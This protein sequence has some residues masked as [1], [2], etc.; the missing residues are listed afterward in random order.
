VGAI[1]EREPEQSPVARACRFGRSGYKKPF[2]YQAPEGIKIDIKTQEAYEVLRD[3]A[4]YFRVTIGQYAG[5]TLRYAMSGAPY[6]PPPIKFTTTTPTTKP[7]SFQLPESLYAAIEYKVGEDKARLYIATTLLGL[8]RIDLENAR[9][10][11]DE[12]DRF[13]PKATTQGHAARLFSQR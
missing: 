12:P 5:R 3:C 13:G 4:K 6:I 7:R 8:A 1:T 11:V 2:V 9:G 10:E